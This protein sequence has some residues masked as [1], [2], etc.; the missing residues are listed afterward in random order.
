MKDFFAHSD[1]LG[2]LFQ[3]AA[4]VDRICARMLELA[5]QADKASPA[6]PP[7]IATAVLA[8]RK[9]TRDAGASILFKIAADHNALRDDDAGEGGDE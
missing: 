9:A 1:P 3:W 7:D 5:D 6:M 2:G 4:E 8:L